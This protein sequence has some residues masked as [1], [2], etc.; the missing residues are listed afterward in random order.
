MRSR[1]FKENFYTIKN[2][3]FY[4]GGVKFISSKKNFKLFLVC[5]GLSFFSIGY[6]F[7]IEEGKLI[8]KK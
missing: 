6:N 1:L 4:C 5:F 2:K 7:G 3:K 8:R